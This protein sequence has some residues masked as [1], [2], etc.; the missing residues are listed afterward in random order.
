M[1]ESR[2]GG[3][4]MGKWGA[5][6]YFIGNIV[7]SGIFITPASVL[8]HSSSVGEA[9]MRVEDGKVQPVGSIKVGIVLIIWAL[10]AVISA[11]GAFCYLVR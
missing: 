9:I 2:D 8:R 11:L 1:L 7:G 4:K 10:S 5:T 3:N 6:S